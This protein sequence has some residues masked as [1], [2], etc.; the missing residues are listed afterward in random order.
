MIKR[1]DT[2]MLIKNMDVINKYDANVNNSVVV[3]DV[4]KIDKLKNKQ[5]N[6]K[7]YSIIRYN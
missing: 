2:Y 4:N 1:Y 7:F 5:Y 6:G 3:K